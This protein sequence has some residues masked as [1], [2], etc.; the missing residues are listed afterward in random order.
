MTTFLLSCYNNIILISLTFWLLAG[1][2]MLRRLERRWV[3]DNVESWLEACGPC[4]DKG[5]RR[6]AMSM[7][8]A[9]WMDVFWGAPTW[10]QYIRVCLRLSRCRVTACVGSFFLYRLLPICYT[11]FLGVCVLRCVW[12]FLSSCFDPWTG[13]MWV[14]YIIN[15]EWFFKSFVC[16]VL[17]FLMVWA[18]LPAAWCNVLSGCLRETTWS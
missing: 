8:W 7:V 3:A 2:Y 10:A 17:M 4:F 12:Q 1:W 6:D 15:F 13:R 18:L 16:H 14:W 9:W 5:E 11:V